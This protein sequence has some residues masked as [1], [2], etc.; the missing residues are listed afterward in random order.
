MSIKTIDDI[1]N[2]GDLIHTRFS[3][4]QWYDFLIDYYKEFVHGKLGEDDEIPE[5][6]DGD[7]VWFDKRG[8]SYEEFLNA[9]WY[10]DDLCD[11]LDIIQVVDHYHYNSETK[12]LVEIMNYQQ[13]VNIVE[14]QIA[15]FKEKLSMLE[16]QVERL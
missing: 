14:T 6:F 1:F 4:H 2:A 15:S 7:D 3:L 13:F 12:E 8:I 9:D 10:F 16:K 5:H 11:L